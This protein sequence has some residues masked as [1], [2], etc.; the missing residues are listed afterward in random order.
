MIEQSTLGG[1]MLCEDTNRRINREVERESQS[2]GWVRKNYA[3]N[4]E[5]IETE[6]CVAE[7]INAP[8][9]ILSY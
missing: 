3:K 4:D 2:M 8:N 1:Q 6:P 9:S 5:Q 7:Y